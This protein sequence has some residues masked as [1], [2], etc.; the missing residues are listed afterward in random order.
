MSFEVKRIYTSSSNI[1]ERRSYCGIFPREMPIEATSR[2]KTHDPIWVIEKN[3]LLS[4][5]H[6]SLREQPCLYVAR[7]NENN[8]VCT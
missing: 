4:T 5:A 7:S 2:A 8:F 3:R 1:L 6:I